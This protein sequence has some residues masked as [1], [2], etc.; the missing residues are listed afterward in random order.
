MK[1]IMQCRS[2]K[3]GKEMKKKLVF[4]FT[5]K[6]SFKLK[7]L[8]LLYVLFPEIW[9]YGFCVL[10]IFIVFMVSAEGV[11]ASG[12]RG[13]I[14]KTSQNSQ[15][16]FSGLPQS[17]LLPT[18]YPS[19][20]PLMHSEEMSKLSQ[21]GLANFAAENIWNAASTSLWCPD[22]WPRTHPRQSTR[23]APHFSSLR[24]PALPPCLSLTHAVCRADVAAPTTVSNTFALAHSLLSHITAVTSL[25]LF[26][27]ACTGAFISSP[28][29]L[30]TGLLTLLNFDAYRI[31]QKFERKISSM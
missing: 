23:E 18:S 9:D 13:G 28:Q 21:T 27:F 20:S 10:F 24:P 5:K 4:E 11:K 29:S 17:L 12:E 31:Q 19:I 22:V 26:Q 30:C 15:R 14:L 8:D 3:G 2:R 7:Y 25:H 1:R 16:F 6:W